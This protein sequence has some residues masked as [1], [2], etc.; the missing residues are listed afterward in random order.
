MKN[1]NFIIAVEINVDELKE[2]GTQIELFLI[3]HIE[4]SNLDSNWT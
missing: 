3:F 1:T 4:Y 2:F